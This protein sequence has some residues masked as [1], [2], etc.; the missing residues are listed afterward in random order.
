MSAFCCGIIA[1]RL[2][3][4]FIEWAYETFEVLKICLLWSNGNPPLLSNVTHHI[5]HWSD[6]GRWEDGRWDFSF[7][8]TLKQ[9]RTFPCETLKSVVYEKSSFKMLGLLL[10]CKLDRGSYILSNAQATF[11]KIEALVCSMNFLASEFTLY[12]Y[13]Q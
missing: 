6:D 5:E 4:G 3:L 2:A 1:W 10:S 7:A 9:I 8:I 13:E 12:L 11:K